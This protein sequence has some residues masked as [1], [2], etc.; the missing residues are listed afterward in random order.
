MK[1]R[2]PQI[3]TANYNVKFDTFDMIFQKHMH[4]YVIN[5]KKKN[6]PS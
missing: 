2:K 3:V 4:I 5:W 1:S 6:S